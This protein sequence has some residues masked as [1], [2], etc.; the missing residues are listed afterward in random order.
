MRAMIYREYGGPERLELTDVPRPTPG[1]GEVLIR[2]VTSSVNPVDWKR[3]S[4][5]Y[6]LIMPV[7]RPAI[8]GFDGAGEVVELGPG[9]T[10]L[11]VGMRVH[12]RIST[13]SGGTS[14]EY[15]AAGIDV[16]AEMPAGMDWAQA[17]ALPL[18]GM[19]ALQGLRDRAGMP[20]EGARGRVLVVGASGGV[21]HLAVQI[22]RAAGA[23]VIG[24]CSGRNA[25]LVSSLGAHEIIDYTKP[26]PYRGQA[27]FDVVLDCVGGSPFPWLSRMAARG[28]F[29]SAFP[30]PSVFLR[31]ALNPLTPKKVRDVML[32]ANAADLRVLDRLFEAGELKVV[33]DG[34]FPLAELR[35][36]WERSISGRSTGKIVIDI[37]PP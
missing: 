7:K 9:V 23:T 18:A 6:R 31:K 17:A 13:G 30:S 4:G 28:R 36:A 27:P 10:G 35:R 34:R 29:V 2:L 21:G 32:K 12:T 16:T 8:P 5:K 24:V 37:A 3:A 15:V 26:D 22:A 14:A 1:P 19:T 25:E 20:L 11:T 33:I